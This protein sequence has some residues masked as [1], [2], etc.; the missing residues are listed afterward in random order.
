MWPLQVLEC[1][2]VAVAAW[3][4]CFCTLFRFGKRLVKE[5]LFSS[6]PKN[7]DVTLLSD[8][9]NRMITCCANQGSLYWPL[10]LISY[11]ERIEVSNR[12]KSD[13]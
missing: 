11:F 3:R 8:P 4:G 12:G 9:C 13:F 5:Q 1:T 6:F 2:H 7:L 10:L